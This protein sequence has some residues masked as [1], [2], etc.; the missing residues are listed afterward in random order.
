MVVSVKP[1]TADS[2][3]PGRVEYAEF[4]KVFPERSTR[5]ANLLRTLC[6]LF[7]R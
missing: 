1:N 4:M 6:R 3:D 5:W 7:S 2:K